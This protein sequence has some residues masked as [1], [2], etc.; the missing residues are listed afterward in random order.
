MSKSQSPNH[1]KE[2]DLCADIM[3]ALTLKK[4][5]RFW[6]TVSIFALI[7]LGSFLFVDNSVTNYG[8]HIAQVTVDHPVES[9]NESWYKQLAL[10]AQSEDA[11]ALVLT[12]DSPGG[13]VH[14]AEAGHA[15]LERIH[16]K[17]P[18]IT[19]VKSQAASAAYLLAC[20]S[21]VI[22]AQETSLVGSIGVLSSV[23][24]IKELLEK[25]GVRYVTN[26]DGRNLSGIP[27]QGLN[28]FT[29][30]FLYQEGQ[31]SYVWFKG[32][33]KRGRKF[34][35][36]QLSQVTEGRVFL[37]REAITLG[38]IDGFGGLPEANYWLQHAK[39]INQQNQLYFVDYSRFVQ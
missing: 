23:T 12:L 16:K 13:V 11:K 25:T 26:G 39:D 18:I 1:P 14:V 3:L 4:K 10:V 28:A 7:Y 36:K 22:F 35:D 17:I 27:F 9:L 37:G 31:D 20:S 6:I 29:K 19:V 32:I 34:T 2:Q 15:L 38:L 5:T 21:D 8:P 30:K 33:V 24:V